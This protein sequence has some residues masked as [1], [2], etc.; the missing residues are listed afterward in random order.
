MHILRFFGKSFL[1]VAKFAKKKTPKIT[2]TEVGDKSSSPKCVALHTGI[3]WPNYP[4]VLYTGLQV[5]PPCKWILHT[6]PQTVWSTDDCVTIDTCNCLLAPQQS[7]PQAEADLF[8]RIFK[9]KLWQTGDR[10]HNSPYLSIR[11]GLT[12]HHSK[13]NLD[14]FCSFCRAKARYTQ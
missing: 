3:S 1:I 10:D 8:S 6:L 13:Q 7:P 9:A 14:P 4:H 11:R 2:A 5:A 12:E